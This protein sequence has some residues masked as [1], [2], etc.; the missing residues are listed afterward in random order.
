VYENNWPNAS[1]QVIQ[2]QLCPYAKKEKS[3]YSCGQGWCIR[4]ILA[5]YLGGVRLESLAYY[6][7]QCVRLPL[8]S[9]G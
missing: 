3:T 1:S 9:S 8:T 7:V 5:R 6:W 2:V 4:R